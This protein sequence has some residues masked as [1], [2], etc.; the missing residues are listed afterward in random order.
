[1]A[2][3]SVIRIWASSIDAAI[4]DPDLDSKH[5]SGQGGNNRYEV[6]WEVGKEPHQW[7][8]FIYNNV[9]TSLA[10]LLEN[11]T[12]LW[13]S[14]VKYLAGSYIVF[15]ENLYHALVDNEE[16][17]K[18]S[19]KWELV[20]KSTSSAFLSFVNDTMATLNSHKALVGPDSNPHN[21]TAKQANTYEISEVD[22]SLKVVRDDLTSHKAQ[23]NAHNL[24]ASVV[25]CLDKTAG[26]HFTGTVVYGSGISFL[27]GQNIDEDGIASQLDS[28]STV[29]NLPY[30][31][32]TK[33][34]VVTDTS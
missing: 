7:T 3:R 14:S 2:D 22:A 10:E 5:P 30:Q 23:S 31:K 28:L 9:D 27:A 21:T 4:T 26:G 32:S 25:N 24:K 8:N 18:S 17:P 1:M 20:P 13:D 11:G 29:G 16:S 6:G 12:L 34:E 19:S 15:E 33:Q